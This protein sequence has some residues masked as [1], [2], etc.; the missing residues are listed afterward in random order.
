MPVIGERTILAGDFAG[1][2]PASRGAHCRPLHPRLAS[3]WSPTT[4]YGA[5]PRHDSVGH[6]GPAD[7]TPITGDGRLCSLGPIVEPR[8]V[9]THESTYFKIVQS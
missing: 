4:K 5:D 9:A 6:P 7:P 8:R 2:V 3:L 1:V